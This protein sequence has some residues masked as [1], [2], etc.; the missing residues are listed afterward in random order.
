M[1]FVLPFIRFFIFLILLTC[2]I[3]GFTTDTSLKD[4]SE[5]IDSGK[6]K[7]AIKSLEKFVQSTKSIKEKIDASVLLAKAYRIDG[8]SA[9]AQEILDKIQADDR[10]LSFQIEYG[11]VR[12]LFKQPDDALKAAKT[13]GTNDH[14]VLR[15][16][17]IWLTTRAMFD[18]KDYKN[19]VSGCESVLTGK[20]FCFLGTL[21]DQY[22]NA[23]EKKEIA[24]ARK[25]AEV[26][27]KI[28]RELLDIQLY[29]RDY[30]WYRMA[31]EYESE[32]KFDLAIRAYVNI[33]LGLL[34][35]A[36]R[37]YT[38]RCHARLGHDKEALK[39]WSTIWTEKPLGLY[40]GEAL[41]EA[42]LLTY[43]SG[44][45]PKATLDSLEL[46][47]Q[48]LRWVGDMRSLTTA[49]LVASPAAPPPLGVFKESTPFGCVLGQRHTKE[50]AGLNE[51][52]I[53]D[54]VGVAPKEM[55]RPDDCGNLVRS[56]SFPGSIDNPLTA[57]WLL[58][59]LSTKATLLKGFL[60][61]EKND[62]D[63]ASEVFK[64]APAAGF[65]AVTIKDSST[66]LGYLI[67]SL[68][69]DS[70]ILP[71]KQFKLLSNKNRNAL[72][73]AFFLHLCGD[74]DRASELF[75]GVDTKAAETTPADGLV[76]RIGKTCV[77]IANG[78]AKDAAEKLE[79]IKNNSQCKRMPLWPMATYLYGC[80]TAPMDA[81]KSADAFTSISNTVKSD[82][83]ARALFANALSIANSGN[84]NETLRLCFIIKKQHPKTPYAKAA[85]TLAVSVG[86]APQGMP[87]APVDIES[88]KV[89]A[90]KRTVVV[91]GGA[92]WRL[93][94]STFEPGDLILY[95]VRVVPRDPCQIVRSISIFLGEFEPTPP[96]SKGNEIVF[97][98]SPL[99]ANALVARHP[100]NQCK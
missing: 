73:L 60:L 54:I 6:S 93:D 67:N 41:Y 27:L 56:K 26:L 95:Q 90:Q 4:V 1:C 98:R 74:D 2:C 70:W 20:E 8:N 12:L 46:V 14:I 86:M 85:S 25:K 18:L 36:A 64:S 10:P 21:E 23:S 57:P 81:K 32:R 24:E 68:A 47:D 80:I 34:K 63:K 78:K 94:M 96:A 58:S 49:S 22:S 50:F 30:A 59:D 13:Y 62:M 82:D 84:K 89:I 37:C 17:A 88:G 15:F 38:A 61:S 52:V 71:E 3:C 7:S 39:G 28:A 29:G 11:E 99:L 91:P 51:A 43:K 31:R 40:V 77:L 44:N 100:G 69:N 9:K 5:K 19:C 72:K 92:E 55:Y 53:R 48:L 65:G 42:A 75:D 35:E 66:T 87:A 83:A 45:N 33:R 79:K 97:L 16:K 76:S